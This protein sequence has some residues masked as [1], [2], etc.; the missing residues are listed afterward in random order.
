MLAV[1]HWPSSQDGKYLAAASCDDQHT[2]HVFGL[3]ANQG[4]RR[5][6]CTGKD[7]ILDLAFSKDSTTLVYGA[8]C[9][10]RC[11]HA[12]R[13]AP[14]G[15]KRFI[16]WIKRQA[17]FCCEFISNEEEEKCVVGTQSGSIYTLD[18]RKL[19][20]ENHSHQGGPCYTMWSY[21]CRG[22]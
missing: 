9:I 21:H 22:G 16:C 18:G 15:E 20:E 5:D 1:P 7:K 6:A 10:I 3:A 11:L 2:L 17:I 12:G 19:A 8:I 13:V 14:E 4:P